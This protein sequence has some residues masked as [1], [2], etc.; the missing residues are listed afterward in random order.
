M[1]FGAEPEEEAREKIMPDVRGCRG[2]MPIAFERREKLPRGGG[3][4][5]TKV[6][7]HFDVSKSPPRMAV[8]EWATSKTRDDEWPKKKKKTPPETNFN[9]PFFEWPKA[10]PRTLPS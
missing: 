6:S 7:C 10:G 4:N 1:H 2:K 3:E 9:V 8:G 5:R